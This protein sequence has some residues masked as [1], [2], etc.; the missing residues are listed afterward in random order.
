MHSIFSDK[1]NSF[2][3]A[4]EFRCNHF[5]PLFRSISLRFMTKKN[6]IFGQF[7]RIV[8]VS[9][10]ETK[11]MLVIKMTIMILYF[12]PLMVSYL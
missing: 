6:L 10:K 1:I 5:F 8:F 7:Q 11:I 4:A 2:S 3:S 12:D 9:D